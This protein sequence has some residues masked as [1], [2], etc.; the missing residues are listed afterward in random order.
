MEN[1]HWRIK[2]QSK[3]E[4]VTL[5][6]DLHIHAT[7]INVYPAVEGLLAEDALLEVSTAA[8]TAALH[9]GQ[10]FR[11]QEAE[12][13]QAHPIRRLAAAHKQRTGTVKPRSTLDAVHKLR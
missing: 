1:G 5:E 11:Q 7:N 8:A 4:R 2:T 3:K 9:R 12:E 10:A 13:S 6:L